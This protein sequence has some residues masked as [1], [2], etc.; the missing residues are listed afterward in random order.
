ML[1]YFNSDNV[2]LIF[3]TNKTTANFSGSIFL[4]NSSLFTLT[5]IVLLINSFLLT[6]FFVYS[7]FNISDLIKKKSG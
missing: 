3:E 2:L 6:I 7:Q 5:T 1:H 4:S